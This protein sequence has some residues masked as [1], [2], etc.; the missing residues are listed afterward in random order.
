MTL[1][2]LIL[3]VAL[4]A[5]TTSAQTPRTYAVEVLVFR[6]TQPAPA[7]EQFGA[8]PVLADP[9]GDQS[10]A[11]LP[12]PVRFGTFARI[13]RENLELDA[14]SRR[15]GESSRFAPVLHDGWMQTAVSEDESRAKRISGG[16][17]GA[18]V[19]GRVLFTRERFLHLDVALNVT[20]DGVAYSIT[21]QRH[22]VQSNKPHYLD[23]PMFGAILMVR[24]IAN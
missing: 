24:P 1:R 11:E 16:V 17:A 23:H 4:A 20:L 5:G 21:E 7:G 8:R 14:A 6:H 13:D 10:S 12:R 2:L 15:L 19:D 22:R 9:A 18:R 3:A